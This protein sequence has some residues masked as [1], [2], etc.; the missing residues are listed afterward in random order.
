[1]VQYY[2]LNTIP[3]LVERLLFTVFT[4]HVHHLMQIQVFLGTTHSYSESLSTL[5][6]GI[7]QMLTSRVWGLTGLAAQN[8][9]AAGWPLPKETRSKGLS[10][11]ASM[12]ATLQTPRLGKPAFPC[13][14]RVFG[15]C[16]FKCGDPRGERL[17]SRACGLVETLEWLLTNEV[18]GMC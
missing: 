15:D 16:L 9:L 3:D 10:T 13:C 5:T 17:E 1:M 4:Q 12:L 11:Q 14:G 8:H 6:S 7:N 18:S 2:I